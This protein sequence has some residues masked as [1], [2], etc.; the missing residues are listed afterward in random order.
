MGVYDGTVLLWEFTPTTKPGD[1]NHDG[2]VSILDLTFVGSNL[3][4]TGKHNAD[5]N[6][7]GIV[8]ILDLV[9]VASI[10]SE[11]MIPTAPIASLIPDR[12]KRGNLSNPHRDTIQGW[13]DMAHA[14]DDGS[15]I[16]QRGIA[17]SQTTLS[18]IATAGDCVVAQLP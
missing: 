9:K 11:T 4:Q 5:V 6:R 3:G 7:D 8:D 12:E 1:V 14:A 10:Y 18:S 13:I 16:Y 17:V 15:L 2:V